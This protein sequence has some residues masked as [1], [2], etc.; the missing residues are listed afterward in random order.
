MKK[1]LLI[2][3]GV[4][5]VLVILIMWRIAAPFGV[6]DELEKRSQQVQPGMST[7]EVQAIMNF[8]GRWRTNASNLGWGDQPVPTN[9]PSAVYAVGYTVPT[10]FRGVTFEF[11]FDENGKA[12][13]KHRHD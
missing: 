10:F 4:A 11:V 8:T 3:A 9:A 7:N 1:K 12:V 6:I 2:I 13:G 5:L